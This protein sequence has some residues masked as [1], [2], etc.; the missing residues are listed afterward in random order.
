MNSVWQET[1][2]LKFPQ[3]K[4]DIRTDVLIIGGG[5]AGILTAY[6]LHQ[7][8]INYV[9]AEGRRIGSGTTGNTTAKITAQH[10]LNYQ[11]IVKSSDVETAAGYLRANLEACSEYARMCS[12]IDCDYEVKDNYVYSINDRKIQ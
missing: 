12:D 8:G 11:K 4:E 10:G 7:E 5:L 3:L 6:R 9:L 1:K 2:L